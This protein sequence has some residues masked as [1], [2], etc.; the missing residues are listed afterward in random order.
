MPY[1][2]KTW[3]EALIASYNTIE[4]LSG[5]FLVSQG[6]ERRPNIMTIGW[7]QGGIIWGRPILTILVRPS[8]Y[9]FV[10]IEE[11]PHFTVCI[12]TEKMKKEIQWCGTQ[13]GIVVDKFQKT[14][15]TS[16]YRENFSVPV[17]QECPIAFECE[18]VQKTRVIETNF[19]QKILNEYYP[20]GDFHTVYYGEILRVKFPMGLSW[21]KEGNN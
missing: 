10:H 15:F 13:S 9:T 4:E 8:R 11:N 1:D 5:V 3:K 17:I 19:S 16:D 20:T 21:E 2:R 14:S 12:P 6:K 18:V 7:L